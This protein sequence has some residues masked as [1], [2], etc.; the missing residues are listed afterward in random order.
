MEE[1]K[2][3]GSGFRGTLVRNQLYLPGEVR[4]KK[5]QLQKGVQK[6]WRD[7]EKLVLAWRDKG[8]PTIMI[9]TVFSAA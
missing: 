1:L 6:A 3:R 8:K 7:G 5:F 9:S 2:K 4:A